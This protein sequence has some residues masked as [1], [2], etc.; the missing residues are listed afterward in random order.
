MHKYTRD[1]TRSVSLKLFWLSQ[2]R[3]YCSVF[4]WAVL[5]SCRLIKFPQSISRSYGSIPVVLYILG[6][7]CTAVSNNQTQYKTFHSSCTQL[8]WWYLCNVS[9]IKVGFL[10]KGQVSYKR[11]VVHF[12]Y[13]FY[14]FYFQQLAP[15]SYYTL[16]TICLT[17]FIR[18][19]IL[20]ECILRVWR[21]NKDEEKKKDNEMGPCSPANTMHCR[22]CVTPFIPMSPQWV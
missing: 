22:K 11:V 18:S 10:W 15:Y 14:V 20:F 6:V 9:W 19:F 17:V 4:S 8:V 16:S 12:K 2:L 1:S 7:A 3:V 5:T 13:L 21:R